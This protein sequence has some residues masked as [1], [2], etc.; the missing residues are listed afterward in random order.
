MFYICART[1]N[2]NI[3]L[4]RNRYFTGNIK[5]K[6][7]TILGTNHRA[8]CLDAMEHS[9]EAIPWFGMEQEY[10]LL[11]VDGHPFGWPKRGFPGPQGKRI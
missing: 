9:K 4:K 1:Y 10:T 6:T 8:T 3:S 11:D 7:K 5:L 2:N